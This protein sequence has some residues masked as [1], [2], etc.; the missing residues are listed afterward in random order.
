MVPS[1]ED[2]HKA[3]QGN[4]GSDT[5]ILWDTINTAFASG[6]TT[7]R[8]ALNSSDA[9]GHRRHFFW[10]NSHDELIVVLYHMLG[11]NF[12]MVEEFF[13]E[14]SRFYASER[15]QPDHVVV[16]PEDA[17]VEDDIPLRAGF[18]GHAGVA[19]DFD[20]RGESQPI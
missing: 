6:G 3:I 8:G 11:Q 1:P 12:D 14:H 4:A 13:T 7:I 19:Y 17:M 9:V 15:T 5:C 10:F 2:C 18:F 16:K 20:P